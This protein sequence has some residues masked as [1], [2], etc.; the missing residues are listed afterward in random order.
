[1]C[2]V[3]FL[4]GFNCVSAVLGKKTLA[5]VTCLRFCCHQCIQLEGRWICSCH[6]KMSLIPSKKKYGE[7]VG[8]SRFSSVMILGTK[9]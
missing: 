8:D 4:G 6:S 3:C 2:F 9:P 5:D 1:M 7:K